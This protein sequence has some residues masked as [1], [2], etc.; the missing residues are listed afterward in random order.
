MGRGAG[1]RHRIER[2][3]GD[4]FLRRLALLSGGTLLGQLVALLTAPLLTRLYTP[5]E[6]GLLGV[7]ASL[8][9]ILGAAVTLRYEFAIPLCA[10]ET[11]AA[12]VAVMAMAA[13]IGLSVPLGLAA[14]QSGPWLA[15]VTNTPELLGTIW[16]LLV[17]LIAWG[18]AQALSFWSIRR[19][20]YRTNAVNNVT[21]LVVQAAAPLGLS[22]IGGVGLVLGVVAANVA[23]LAHFLLT[24]PL[25]DRARLRAVR[26]RRLWP[27]ARRRWQY[28]L[29]AG[30][31]ALLQSSSRFLPTMLVATL[32]GPAAA[33]W[34]ALAQ[35]MLDL[36]II[37]LAHNASVVFLGEARGLT[38]V[39]A[40]RL[41]L[42]TMARFLG[43]GL[44]AMGPLLLLGPTLFALVFG[45]EWRMAGAMVQC[46]VPV[47]LARFVAVP[48][49]QTLNVYRR[50][51]LHLVAGAL[52]L[53]AIAFA[54]ALGS[55]LSWPPLA[56]LLSFS[57]GSALTFLLYML[58]TWR[59]MPRE[60]AAADGPGRPPG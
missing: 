30:P 34:F 56:T 33:G 20:A 5:D 25:A 3:R 12:H 27:L 60:A 4:R 6:F 53:G 49:S 21:R 11:A 43:L 42:R 58:L 32:Y 1:I 45:D 18:L 57:L 41:F 17:A 15:A 29:F 23:S 52:N 10:T 37:L 39:E 19:G 14:W 9:G 36:P 47:Q 35:R 40:R 55:T 38:P 31:S 48:I 59:V 13:T 16:L 24:L 8:T 46:L 26:W 2:L 51:D 44:V 7:F 50:Q 54:F 22:G 28:P